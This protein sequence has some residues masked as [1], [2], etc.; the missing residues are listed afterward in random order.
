MKNNKCILVYGLENAEIIE[1]TKRKIKFIIIKK[2]MLNIKIKDILSGLKSSEPSNF[3]ISE[4]VILFN[5][6]EDNK[7]QKSI[8]EI[9]KFVKGGILAVVTETSREW[10][11][12]YLINHLIE[13]R[14]WFKNMQK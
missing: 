5:N 7:L 10:S 11:F 13:E 4:K 9:R 8:K 14:E 3:N 2:E 1:L 6:Y 12:E